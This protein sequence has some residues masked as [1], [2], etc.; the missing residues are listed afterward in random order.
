MYIYQSCL[1]L[2]SS[3]SWCLPLVFESL[4]ISSCPLL[5]GPFRR[6][7]GL[8]SSIQIKPNTTNY[9]KTQPN[10]RDWGLRLGRRRPPYSRSEFLQVA[11]RRPNPANDSWPEK[12]N[13]QKFWQLLLTILANMI[14]NSDKYDLQFWQIFY[15]QLWQIW[16]VNLTNMI[17][18][19]NKYDALLT[20][21]HKL[22]NHQ[23]SQSCKSLEK[24][25]LAFLLLQ[26]YN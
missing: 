13:H 3:P 24:C 17:S 18:N 8:Q 2:A 23:F 14:C 11:S 9:N 10:T 25:G 12:Y 7:F 16:S 20:S 19:T 21:V 1:C 4:P 22:L 5:S 6:G 26:K 15:L